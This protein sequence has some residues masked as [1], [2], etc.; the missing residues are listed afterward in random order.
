MSVLVVSAEYKKKN[1]FYVDGKCCECERIFSLRKDSLKTH[2]GFCGIC[3][4]RKKPFE[5][6][7]KKMM[8][9]RGIGGSMTYEQYVEFTKI[10]ECHYCKE[11]IQ[12][13]EYR[14]KWNLNEHTKSKDYNRYNIDRKDPL[15]KY[16]NDNC[17]VCCSRC[18][19]GKLD[20]F[21]YEEWYGMTEY[22]RNKKLTV[23]CPIR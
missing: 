21:S 14:F 2:Q 9:S 3:Q 22:L 16:D 12:W 18:N 23:A 19:Y 6:I 10:P 1:K 11:T 17:V 20:M 13:Q 7:Y 4:N 5:S 15:G 8:V